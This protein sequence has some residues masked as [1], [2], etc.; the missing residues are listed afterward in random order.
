[1]LITYNEK[2]SEKEYICVYI[3]IL[4]HFI[5]VLYFYCITGP[6]G[7]FQEFLIL[8]TKDTKSHHESTVSIFHRRKTILTPKG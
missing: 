2:G 3:L 8:V 5:P 1:M 4:N 6:L 7:N